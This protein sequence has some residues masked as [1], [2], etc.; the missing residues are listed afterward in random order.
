MATIWEKYISILAGY[1]NLGYS[2]LTTTVSKCR[3][4]TNLIQQISQGFGSSVSKKATEISVV[5]ICWTNFKNGFDLC[6][7]L[8]YERLLT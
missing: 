7:V 4:I 3:W 2:Y 6:E 8:Y 1:L 5:G